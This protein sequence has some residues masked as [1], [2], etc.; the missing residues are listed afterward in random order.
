[1]ERNLFSPLFS[2]PEKISP[3]KCLDEGVCSLFCLA[4]QRKREEMFAGVAAAAAT[5]PQE[6][7]RK[8][9]RETGSPENYSLFRHYLVFT[10]TKALQREKYQM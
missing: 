8:E 7:G 10:E 1:M 3:H 2:F 6:M 5:D 4:K 9:F